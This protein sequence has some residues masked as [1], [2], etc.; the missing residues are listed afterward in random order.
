MATPQGYR[1]HAR[2]KDL[3]WRLAD[4]HTLRKKQLGDVP[5][6]K[7]LVDHQKQ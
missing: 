5:T 4:F 1:S 3:E 2:P 7:E 6:V